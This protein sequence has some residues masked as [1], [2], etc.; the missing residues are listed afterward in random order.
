MS[1]SSTW[2][3]TPDGHVAR[4][5]FGD[6]GASQMTSS[7]FK[8]LDSILRS[9][10]FIDGMT[11]GFVCDSPPTDIFVTLR[12]DRQGAL[13]MQAVTGCVFTGPP[14]NLPRQVNDLVTSTSRP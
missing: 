14:G 13:K 12:L 6:A 9:V 7:D 3:V 8:Q 5:V 4:T 2:A 11:N 1:C 10:P